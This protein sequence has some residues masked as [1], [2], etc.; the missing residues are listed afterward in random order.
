MQNGD[1]F[2]RKIDSSAGLPGRCSVLGLAGEQF[3]FAA[4]ELR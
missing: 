4:I 2:V 3:S 1:G